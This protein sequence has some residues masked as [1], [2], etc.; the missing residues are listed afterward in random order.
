MV[1]SNHMQQILF[2]N[3]DESINISNAAY[4]GHI[5]TKAIDDLL[6]TDTFN[7]AIISIYN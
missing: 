6:L 2:E 7:I 3:V 1:E 5:E 4:V